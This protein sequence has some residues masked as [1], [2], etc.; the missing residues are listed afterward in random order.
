M[1]VEAAMTKTHMTFEFEDCAN[2]RGCLQVLTRDGKYYW[3][4]NCDVESEQYLEESWVE[5]PTALYLEL[6]AYH[7]VIPRHE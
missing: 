5:I 1:E 7:T 6:L 2:Y 4:V 3:R